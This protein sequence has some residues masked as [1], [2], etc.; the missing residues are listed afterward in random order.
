MLMLDR[1]R[2]LA[3]D[4]DILHFYIDQFHFPLFRPIAH[5]T[6]T[7]PHGPAGP[8][9]PGRQRRRAGGAGNVRDDVVLMGRPRMK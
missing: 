1:V 3:D 2:E 4:F 6:V 5:R 9:R 8:A 7:T